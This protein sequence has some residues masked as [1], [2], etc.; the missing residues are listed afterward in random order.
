MQPVTKS[1]PFGVIRQFFSGVGYLGRG[2]G[3]WATNPKL[4][5]LGAVPALIVGIVYLV[6]IIF[7][8]TR[9]D[10]IAVWMTPF[11]SDWV[12]IWRIA[13]RVAAALAVV[14]VSALVIVYTYAAVTLAVGDPFY[15]RIWRAVER[16][17]G[18][19]PADSEIGVWRTI[20]RAIGDAIR[21]L[22]PAIGLGIALIALGFIPVVGSLLTIVLGAVFGGWL[23]VVELTGFTFDA[24]GF[25]VKQRRQALGRQRP[26]S[27]GFGVATYLLFLIPGA[28]VVV[29]PAAVAGA[30]LLSRE[31]I[32]ER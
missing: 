26:T 22:L 4:M 16:K 30:V 20:G 7:L 2:F 14:V 24:R 25:T 32:L 10:S 27:L 28:A 17:M 23:L 15:E 19:A 8:I 21:L 29:M 11:A 5:L 3:M 13:V 12:E 9:L 18:N 31:R 6:G 1:A